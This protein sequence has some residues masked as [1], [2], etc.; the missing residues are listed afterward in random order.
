MEERQAAQANLKRMREEE[1]NKA[2]VAKELKRK[3]GGVSDPDTLFY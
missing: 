1:K 2:N 3:L